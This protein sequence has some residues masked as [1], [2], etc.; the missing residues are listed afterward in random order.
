M[1]K[2]CIYF[3][4][5]LGTKLPPFYL[6]STKVDNIPKGYRGSVSSAKY[7]Q[8]WRQELKQHPELFRT[9]VIPNQYANTQKDILDL[10]YKWQKIFDVVKSPLFVNLAYAN[11]KFHSTSESVARGVETRRKN[12]NG[13]ITRNPESV[14]K[15]VQTKT[16]LGIYKITNKRIAEERVK[17]G[18]YKASAA[19][20][21]ATKRAI[22]NDKHT[23]ESVDKIKQLKLGLKAW[24]NG[25]Q[26]QMARECPGPGWIKGSLQKPN[27]AWCIGSKY[28]N[29]GTVNKRSPEC[30]GEG[31]VLGRI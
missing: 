15:M 18:S 13:K 9:I 17:N 19:K 2:Y 21:L 7:A 27:L 30:P 8:I 1:H 4:I 28:W 20:G 31:W 11:K 10:E 14:A 5:Y 25:V 6:G 3:T 22:G 29:N 12:G 23:P 16:E 24:N 26:T